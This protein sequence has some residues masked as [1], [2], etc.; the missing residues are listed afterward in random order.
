MLAEENHLR[1]KLVAPVFEMRQPP[2]IRVQ[3]TAAR[4]ENALA[5]AA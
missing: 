5:E 2:P 1:P 4:F 3:P